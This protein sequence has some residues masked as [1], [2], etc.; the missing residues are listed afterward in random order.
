MEAVLRN[1]KRRQASKKVRRLYHRRF[2]GAAFSFA[3]R[4]GFAPRSKLPSKR[5]S[6]PAMPPLRDA[7]RMRGPETDW[8]DRRGWL[9]K[10]ELLRIPQ[11][12]GKMSCFGVTMKHC[13]FICVAFLLTYFA[14]SLLGSS[15]NPVEWPI[16]IKCLFVSF[17]AGHVAFA[18]IQA[19]F[20]HT[21]QNLKKN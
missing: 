4:H 9:S 20:S 8:A 17:C 1:R 13:E 10:S 3:F 6:L 15:L 7:L 19:P 5:V 11:Q 21:S 12:L 16:M 14:G 2:F 18:Y